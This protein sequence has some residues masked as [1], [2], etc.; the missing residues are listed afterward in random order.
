MSELPAG[1]VTL[2]FS[3]IEGSTALL[4]RLGDGWPDVL[5]QQRGLLREAVAAGDGV[6][7]DCQG[8]AMFAAFRSAPSGVAA[9]IVAQ[10]QH[11]LAEWPDGT[12]VRVR[13]SLHTGEPHLTDEGGY[14]GIDVVRAA[15]LCAAGHGG[16]V[17]LT[18]ATR[19]ISGADTIDL[20][21]TSLPDMDGPE[22]VYQLVAPGLGGDFPPLRHTAATPLETLERGDDFDARIER[23]AEAFEQRITA[24]WPRESS[25]RSRHRRPGR[26][27]TTT[28]DLGVAPERPACLTATVT[29]RLLVSGRSVRHTG[30]GGRSDQHGTCRWCGSD[31]SRAARG[32]W[33]CR[34]RGL[35]ARSDDADP[36]QLHSARRC[37][38]A[39]RLSQGSHER[40]GCARPARSGR[41]EPQPVRPL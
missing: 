8:D 29:D 22:H 18:E 5:K 4:K 35:V 28:A 32:R 24:G 17:L 14:T 27:A 30:E 15:R 9:A 26:R 7:V 6:V 19:L 16:Q 23:A 10:R 37:R 20:G 13:M 39:G 38:R 2:M 36:G 25:V 3:D 34:R 40:R 31:M 33:G 1:T 21:S 12:A 11:T 41:H